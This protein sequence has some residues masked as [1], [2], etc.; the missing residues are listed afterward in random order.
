MKEFQFEGKWRKFVFENMP[1]SEAILQDIVDEL[2]TKLNVLVLPADINPK[3]NKVVIYTEAKPRGEKPYGPM[4]QRITVSYNDEGEIELN[5]IVAY[6]RSLDLI[7]AIDGKEAGKTKYV[8]QKIW[9]AYGDGPLVSIRDLKYYVKQLQKGLKDEAQ[10][11]ADF[12]RNRQP[13]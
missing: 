8:G 9:M 4:T 7:G 1:S 6:S 10:A 12:Y 13:D 3:K 5:S 2:E 11:Q